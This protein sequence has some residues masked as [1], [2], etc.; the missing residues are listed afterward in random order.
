MHRI[1]NEILD[2]KY[3]VINVALHHRMRSGASGRDIT[4]DFTTC[5]PSLDRPVVV[6]RFRQKYKQTLYTV[7]MLDILG[8][9]FGNA[10]IQTAR[11]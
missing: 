6:A 10:V 9:Y 8:G 11:E 3:A 2:I 7:I 5:F 1:T 4:L